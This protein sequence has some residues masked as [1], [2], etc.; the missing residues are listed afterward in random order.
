MSPRRKFRG[1]APFLEGKPQLCPCAA[2]TAVC[3]EGQVANDSRT[4]DRTKSRSRATIIGEPA[5]AGGVGCRDRFCSTLDRLAATGSE[6]VNGVASFAQR[7]FRGPHCGD[8][9]LSHPGVAEA[10]DAD[11]VGMG[12]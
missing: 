7:A 5:A 2:V 11:R 10:A 1:I 4:L 9:P 8:Q 3:F 6:S 12:A